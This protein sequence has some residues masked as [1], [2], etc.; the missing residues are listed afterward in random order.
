MDRERREERERRGRDG[1]RGKTQSREGKE[2]LTR[3]GG[4]GTRD[5]GL[6]KRPQD[7]SEWGLNVG[8]GGRRGVRGLFF[9]MNGVDGREDLASTGSVVLRGIPLM[10]E[11]VRPEVWK[12]GPVEDFILG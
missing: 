3:D 2:Y 8:E 10:V 9:R 12:R 5:R 1:G 7:F 4:V 11:D 6:D